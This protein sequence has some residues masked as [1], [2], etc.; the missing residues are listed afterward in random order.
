MVA[1]DG[2]EFDDGM[3][4]IQFLPLHTSINRIASNPPA[5]QPTIVT[6]TDTP[7]T[8][9]TRSALPFSCHKDTIYSL[10]NAIYLMVF[11]EHFRKLHAYHKNL[12]RSL[13][14]FGHKHS[15]HLYMMPICVLVFNIWIFCYSLMP[16]VIYEFRWYFYF[17]S[18]CFEFLFSFSF[19]PVH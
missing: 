15:L 19:W 18:S 10:W 12:R 11:L 5:N 7:R 4:E 1:I 13:L 14:Y 8:F 9:Y 3:D 16:L 6:Q 17:S 2:D